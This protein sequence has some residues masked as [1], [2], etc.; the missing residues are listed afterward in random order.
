MSNFFLEDDIKDILD[1]TQKLSNK[2]AGKHIVLTGGR[3]FLGKY[4][5][6]YFLRLNK[7]LKKPLF[8][9]VLDNL[10]IDGNIN[11]K[12]PNDRYFKFLNKDVSH[13]FKIKK[14]VDFFIH[15]AGIASPFYYRKKPLETLD[16]TINGIRSILEMAKEN[17][18]KVVFFSSSE[19]YGDPDDKNV[20]MKETYRGNVSTSGPRACYDESKRLGETLCYIYNQYFNV[21]TNI[22]RP[23]NVY[24]PGMNQYDYRIL[25]NFGNKIKNKEILSIYGTGKQTRTYCY[26]NDAIVGFLKV[27][28]L[29]KN[30][31]TYNIGNSNPEISALELFKKI[32]KIVD[33]KIKFKIIQYPKSYPTDEPQ[34]RC[35]DISKSIIHLG[36]KPTI[37]LDEGLNKFFKWSQLNYVKKRKIKKT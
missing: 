33:D 10:T 19:I 29:G 24:G 18:A 15:A 35:P 22:I 31:E 25:P 6:E 12:I 9:T 16:V 8:L 7:K 17:S 32:D 2:L 27:I 21:H 4:L 23:F 1:R 13:P 11:Q 20:P 37:S 28:V 3:G 34:R 14:K 30:G 36:F 26:I 5:T